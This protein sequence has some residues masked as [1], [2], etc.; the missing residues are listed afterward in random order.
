M[1]I[2]VKIY[3]YI[4]NLTKFSG[5]IYQKNINYVYVVMLDALGTIQYGIVVSVIVI[6]ITLNDCLYKSHHDYSKYI[7]CNFYFLS[8]ITMTSEDLWLAGIGLIGIWFLVML[9]WIFV[10]PFA[11]LGFGILCLWIALTILW[12]ATRNK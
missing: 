10:Q 4:W 2:T 8:Y 12:L 3:P 6:Q 11:W 9:F 1:I 5:I 7:Y